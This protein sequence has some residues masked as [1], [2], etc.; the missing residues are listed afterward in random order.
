LDVGPV[1]ANMSDELD[2]EGARIRP[3]DDALNLTDM[4]R[5]AGAPALN[6]LAERNRQTQTANFIDFISDTM[7]KAHGFLIWTKAR[8]DGG[9][10][11]HWQIGMAYAEY[12]SR[13]LPYYPTTQ[14]A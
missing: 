3:K 11:A 4:W 13:A 5:A 9:T 10:L 2:F 14:S 7:G 1:Q 8:R 6:P 12:P